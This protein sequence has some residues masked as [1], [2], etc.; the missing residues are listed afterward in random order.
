M[1]M[2]LKLTVTLSIMQA[3]ADQMTDSFCFFPYFFFIINPCAC[4]IG[5]PG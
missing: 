2:I 4:V 3:F 1:A 5:Y